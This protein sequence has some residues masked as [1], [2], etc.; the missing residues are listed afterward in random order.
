MTP[1]NA[2]NQDVVWSCDNEKVSITPNGLSCDVYGYDVGSAVITVMAKDNTN[3]VVSD[4]LE[5]TVEEA[6]PNISPLIVSK[7]ADGVEY[8]QINDFDGFINGGKS[9]L[10]SNTPNAYTNDD[11]QIHGVITSLLWGG[12]Q[13]SADLFLDQ[14]EVY[15]GSF[16]N[17]LNYKA[18]TEKIV[19]CFTGSSLALRFPKGFEEHSTPASFIADKM[20]VLKLKMPE[21]YNTFTID[22]NKITSMSIKSSSTG[23]QY[24]QFGYSDLPASNIYSGIN[25]FSVKTSTNAN[26]SSV[27]PPGVAISTAILSLTFKPDTF[28]DFT[29][30]NVKEYI[31]NNPIILYY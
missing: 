18:Q 19:L 25:T 2:T 23:A 4:K 20:G 6:S 29:L 1:S 22:P 17:A 3:G 12:F 31:T 24:A 14:F 26:Q 13:T 7:T 30:D 28:K 10:V 15:E 9:F 11:W 8:A 16:S 27:I 5:I 21:T